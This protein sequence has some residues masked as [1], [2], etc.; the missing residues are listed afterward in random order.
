MPEVNGQPWLLLV[1]ILAALGCVAIQP[2]PPNP[3]VVVHVMTVVMAEGGPD[4]AK[5]TLEG[6]RWVQNEHLSSRIAVPGLTEP[7]LCNGSGHCLMV[8]GV[9]PVEAAASMMAAGLSRDLDLKHTYFLIAG[10]AGVSPEVG[11]VGTVAWAEWVVSADSKS[12][13]DIRELPPPFEF[14]AFRM[15]CQAPWC[16]GWPGEVGAYHLNPTLQEWAVQVSRRIQL[17]DSDSVRAYC[18]A[19]PPDS[20]AR[21]APSVVRG[22]V[23]AASA[24]WH[25]NILGR[26][27]AWWVKQWT[28]G[29]G[30]YCMTDNEDFAIVETLARLAKEGRVDLDRVMV[31]RAASNFDRPHPGQQVLESL[32]V[33][34]KG[35]LPL[36]LENAY[37]AGSAVAREILTNWQQWRN[38]VPPLSKS[39]GNAR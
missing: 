32:V 19:Y 35:G 34:V 18:N 6:A 24:W 39:F 21:Q 36:A 5:W 33:P 27:A 12:E 23:L 38:G 26:W 20:A 16:D 1:S 2:S 9:G 17:M 3:P 4:P 14:S 29:A 37:R 30:R 10:I 15:L 31:L 7:V 25:G 28:A 8:T 11:T 13:V 22:D